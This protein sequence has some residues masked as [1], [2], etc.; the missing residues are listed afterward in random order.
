MIEY[1]IWAYRALFYCRRSVLNFL[2]EEEVVKPTHH[3]HVNHIPWL[4]VGGVTVDD[5]NFTVTNE[6][7]RAIQYG[8]LV[9][10]N[11]LESVTGIPGVVT[12]KYLDPVELEEKEF[13]SEGFLIEDATPETD[14]VSDSGYTAETD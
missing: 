5:V 11:Y 13:P 2:F 8:T 10:P 1:I 12:W 3:V 9:T 14:K 4:W 6:V 7:N